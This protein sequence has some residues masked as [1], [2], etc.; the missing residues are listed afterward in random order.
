MEASTTNYTLSGC[1]GQV[2]N[3][4]KEICAYQCIDPA[5]RENSRAEKIMEEM[6]GFYEYTGGNNLFDWPVCDE[7]GRGKAVMCLSGV[8]VVVQHGKDDDSSDLINRPL[9]FSPPPYNFISAEL[10]TMFRSCAPAG[11]EL[12]FKNKDLKPP[13]WKAGQL[14]LSGTREGNVQNPRASLY[15][16][17]NSTR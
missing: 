16:F 10:T 12:G 3:F 4:L 13:A 6:F 7:S 17:N 1:S 11:A 14:W 8:A 15:K 5:S 9:T 2:G